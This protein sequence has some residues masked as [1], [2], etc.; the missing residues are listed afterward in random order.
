MAKEFTVPDLGEGVTGG[1]VIT[2][3]VKEGD[4]VAPDQ[5][6][7]EIETG[8]ATV[9]LPSSFSG[10]IV[11]LGV[12]A[13]DKVR[14]GQNILS[15][16]DGKAETPPAAQPK[17][18]P[19]KTAPVKPSA[20][21]Q[22]SQPKA[23][24]P[25]SESNP[26]GELRIPELGEGVTEGTVLA[27]LVKAGD[28][29]SADQPLL[30][31]ETGKA[32][33]ELPSTASGKVSNVLLKEGAKAKVGDVILTLD[34]GSAQAEKKSSTKSSAKPA[35]SAPQP[36]RTAQPEIP[37]ARAAIEPGVTLGASH[38]PVRA[39][40]SVRKFAR[41][42]GVDIQRVPFSSK[43]GRI[44]IE[45]VKAYTKQLVQQKP[46]GA[47]SAAVAPALE[48]P[49][50]TKWGEITREPQNAIRRVTA[51]HMSACWTT[52]PH[53]TQHHWADITQLEAMRKQYAKKAEKAGGKLTLTAI[54]L[55]IVASALK[56]FPKFNASIDTTNNEI[57]YKK[58]INIGVAVD[59]PK[60]LLVPVI[61][62]VDAKNIIE[63]AAELTDIA[64]RARENKISPKDLQGG[65]F[66]LTNLGG[67]G[68]SHFT[69]IVNCP[70]VAIL[71][72]GRGEQRPVYMDGKF[73]PRLMMPLSLSYD[74][75]LID[76]ADGARF[77]VWIGEAIN[78]PLLMALEG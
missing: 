76:G 55:K 57:I 15:Y 74:H 51:A 4:T 69:P 12:K 59:T 20:A 77:V 75:R 18:E 71:G 19:A 39:A 43:D 67:I 37:S 28:T 44:T 22:A 62:N 24:T 66:T 14:T 61:R 3:L 45:D 47:A 32:T 54:L 40:P 72:V 41:E 56:A 70:E 27:V 50:F 31:I 30:E 42:L 60:G 35:A 52:I 34:G 17:D 49:D 29:I 13:G 73:E 7:L 26:V 46:K 23:E 9:E 68:G 11:K 65:T 1:D 8:K 78:E 33:V 10:K 53:V 16:E 38:T 2:V 36:E 48:L 5:G 58:Y 64:N 63:I 25:I 21:K 6:L